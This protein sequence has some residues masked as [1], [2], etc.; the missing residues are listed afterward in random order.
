MG[1]QGTA[2]PQP[3][4]PHCPRDPRVPAAPPTLEGIAWGASRTERGS[5][6]VEGSQQ[7]GWAGNLCPQ[8]TL[9]EPGWP[10][11]L[12]LGVLGNKSPRS[13]SPKQL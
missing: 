10:A 13:D 5:Q 12:Q 1:A 2:S 8:D 3:A 9:G 7:E 4:A 11:P 6:E